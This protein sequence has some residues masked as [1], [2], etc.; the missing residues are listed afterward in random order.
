[1][2]TRRSLIAAALGAP[3]LA[4]GPVFAQ[5][6][7]AVLAL[8]PA[9][10]AGVSPT[11]ALEEGPYFKPNAPLRHDLAQEAPNGEKI[12]LAGVV[13]DRTCQ[14]IPGAQVQLWH[15]DE[16]GHYD[17]RGFRLRGHQFTDAAGRWW[18]S[19]IVP[20]R[21]FGRTRHYHIKVQRPNGPVLTTQL[22]F[23]GEAG[24]GRD[25]L[26]REQLLLQI[27]RTAEGQFGR[28]DFVIA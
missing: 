21:Y 12:L 10:G 26:F 8:T 20:A 19:T 4:G 22:Y 13:M 23:P 28:F 6:S 5:A 9:C 25:R 27:D 11:T 14:P 18:F 16:D 15:A 7:P 3:F 24:N 1:M 2:Q 17:N